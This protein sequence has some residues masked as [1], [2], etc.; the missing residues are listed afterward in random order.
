MHNSVTSTSN[1][2]VCLKMIS[3]TLNDI[4]IINT[5][6]GSTMSWPYVSHTCH[7]TKT[8]PTTADQLANVM[9]TSIHH[10]LCDP[11]PSPPSPLRWP[12]ST[13]FSLLRTPFPLLRT[14]FFLFSAPLFPFS[15]PLFSSYKGSNGALLYCTLRTHT[16]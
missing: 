11:N 8:S 1:F 5:L 7:L 13:H 9:I 15:T 3:L 12:Q 14:P 4:V 6:L 10:V 2:D 16:Q